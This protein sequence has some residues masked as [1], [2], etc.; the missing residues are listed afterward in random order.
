MAEQN[1]HQF[2]YW[3]TGIIDASPP[4]H[5]RKKGADRGIDGRIFFFDDKTGQAK[6]IIVQV[7]SGNV[8]PQHI[9]DLIGT[10]TSEKAVMGVFITLN[11]PTKPMKDAALSA[12]FYEGLGDKF[13]KL[14]IL[15]VREL[16]AGKKPQYKALSE[17]TFKR[18]KRTVKEPARSQQSLPFT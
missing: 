4:I 18:A 9:R 16:L 10:L 15:T 2:E 8:G 11:E 14:Q 17:A 5:E 13:P 1:R 3:A 6:T 12:G 7:K